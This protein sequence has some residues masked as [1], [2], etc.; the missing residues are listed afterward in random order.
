MLARRA[1]RLRDYAL[2]ALAA[3]AP[4]LAVGVLALRA[5]SNENAAA[6]RETAAGLDAAGERL[7]LGIHQALSRSERALG[8]ARLD[9]P[10]P[11]LART[12]DTLRPAFATVVVLG[13]DRALLWPAP[14]QKTQTPAPARCDAFARTLADPSAHGRAAARR[15]LLAN[16]AELQSATGRW[17]WPVVALDTPRSADA[18]RIVDWLQRHAGLLSNA[19]REAIRLALGTLP[20]PARRRALAALSQGSAT[21]AALQGELAEA[22]VAKALSAAPDSAGVVTWHAGS[23]LGALRPLADGRLVGFVVD[24]ASLRQAL[25]QGALAAGADTRVHVQRGEGRPLPS[26][27]ALPTTLSARVALAPALALAV[28]P[29]DPHA[30]ARHA[31][32][33]RQLLAALALG[34]TLVAFGVA[35]LLFAR[36]R[37]AQRSSELR[38]DFVSA[39]SHELRTPIASVRMFAE[40]LEEDRVEPGERREVVDAIAREARRLGETVDRLLGFSRMAAGRAWWNGTRSALPTR[41]RRP[42]TPSNSAIRTCPRSSVRS[43]AD[44]HAPIDAAQI[45]LA[46]DNLLENARKYAPEGAPYRVEVAREGRGVAIRV[47]DRGPGIALRDQ[48]RIF[49]SFERADD[50]LSRATE[51]SGIGLS[52]V[53]HVAGA[54]GGHARVDSRP[55]QGATFIIWIPGNEA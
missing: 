48:K 49:R 52:L 46:L 13:A 23:T 14:P 36:L 22:G 4:A 53:R 16:C 41:S 31:E 50:R 1:L 51:G 35:A 28:V 43:T 38:T 15:A 54:H 29:A 5:L 27:H 44:L 21:R 34:S 8:A 24:A 6:L 7:S 47:S 32:Q 45:R 11:G 26:G 30:V 20:A 25:D 10:T 19:Q 12:L 55:G 42:S 9:R 18:P 39:V 40:L 33:N 37:A 17:I 2:F 3:L